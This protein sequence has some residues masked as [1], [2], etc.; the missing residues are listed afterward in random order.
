MISLPVSPYVE[1]AR[2]TLDRRGIRYVEE[3]HAPVFHVLATRRH[4]GTGVVPVVDI[5]ERSLTDARQVVEYYGGDL[6]QDGARPLFDDI[7]D[8]LGVAVRA[9]AYAY[10]LPHRDSTVRAWSS[11][12][13]P[14]LEQRLVR[15]LFPLLAAAVRANLKLQTDSVPTQRE[16]IDASLERLAERLADGRRYLLGDRLSAAD[17]ALATLF[18]PAVLP[19]EYVGPLP[20]PAELP[21][22]MRRDVEQFRS[23]PAGQFAL[24]LYREE[25]VRRA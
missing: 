13:V 12:G 16:L 18:A 5:G 25:R 6:L 19:P 14:T 8:G 17:L 4:G 7:F 9:W 22:P 24:R 21:A 23:H 20:S 15:I 2:W 10:M 11:Y 3:A 1:L